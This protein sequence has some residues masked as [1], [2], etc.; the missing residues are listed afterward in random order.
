MEEKLE[1][2]LSRLP[3]WIW[4]HMVIVF[5]FFLANL[6]KYFAQAKELK[7]LQEEESQ[8]KLVMEATQDSETFQIAGMAQIVNIFKQYNV[9]K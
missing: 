4:L 5:P 3:N 6:P 8:L 2:L 1:R 7:K 9:S